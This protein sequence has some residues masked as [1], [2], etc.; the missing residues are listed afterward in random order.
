MK[1]TLKDIAKV[2]ETSV[3]TVS[4][5]L[6]DRPGTYVGQRTRDRVKEVARQ[7]EYR[8]NQM[9]RNLRNQRSMTIGVLTAG[10]SFE[11]HVKVLQAILAS[12]GASGYSASVAA[13]AGGRA[14]ARKALGRFLDAR[15]EGVIVASY[16]FTLD[17]DALDDARRLGVP[18]VAIDPNVPGAPCAV[19]IDREAGAFRATDHLLSL[20]RR[21]LVFVGGSYPSTYE[22]ESARHRGFRRAHESHGLPCEDDRFHVLGSGGVSGMVDARFESRAGERPDG[23]VCLSDYVAVEVLG[24]L[25]RRGIRVP[26]DVAVVGFGNIRLSAHTVP[27]LSTMTQPGDEAGA[28][29]ME[30][31]FDAIE[32]ERAGKEPETF[33]LVITP[34]LVVRESCG[35]K[36]S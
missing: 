3:S 18:V 16:G 33:D 1:V 36:Q 25:A 24:E 20:G 22:T 5:V 10:L 7:L 9:A 31:L 2:A 29:A 30:L 23:L 26:Q 21:N 17:G 34:Q 4:H 8:P 28:R 13:V 14:E 12:A 15:V 35:G 6:N 11:P 19:R 27:S 32:T